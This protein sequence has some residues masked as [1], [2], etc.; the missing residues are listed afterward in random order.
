MSNEHYPK[1]SSTSI[2]MKRM[3]NTGDNPVGIFQNKLA[4]NQ[5]YFGKI[6]VLPKKLFN[7]VHVRLHV[8]WRLILQ[9]VQYL[10]VLRYAI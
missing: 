9:D 8:R 2:P 5:L 7:M 4:L 1:E 10:R 6:N 3:L